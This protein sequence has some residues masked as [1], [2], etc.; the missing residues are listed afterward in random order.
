MLLRPACLPACQPRLFS[1]PRREVTHPEY[2]TVMRMLKVEVPVKVTVE[3]DRT[4]SG[5][6]GPLH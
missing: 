4:Y 5:L 3:G 6:L 1:H 2:G